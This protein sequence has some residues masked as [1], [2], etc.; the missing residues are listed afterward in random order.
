MLSE[1]PA[2]DKLILLGDFNAGVGK[3]HEA[4]PQTL[5]NIGTGKMNSN[6]E[7]L[8]TK[9]SEYQLAITNM[10]LNFSDKRY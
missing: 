3:D 10:F 9:C 7:M 6:G 5:G 1:N 8:S 4:W 2:P